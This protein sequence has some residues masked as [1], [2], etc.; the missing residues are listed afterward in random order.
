MRLPYRHAR[1]ATMDAV[2]TLR[3]RKSDRVD[4]IREALARLRDELAEYGRLH[5]GRFWIYG[6]A[7]SGELHFESDI[8]VIADFDPE[9]TSGAM[10]FLESRASD[11]R[12]RIDAQPKAWCTEEFLTRIARGALVLP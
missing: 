10:A 9:T 7:A 11:L 4:Q 6:S 5:G 8:D 2:V 3:R 12:L 1:L